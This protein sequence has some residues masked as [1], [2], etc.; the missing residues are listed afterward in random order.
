MSLS[1]LPLLA[2]LAGSPVSAQDSPLKGTLGVESAL[3]E[4]FGDEPQGV[5]KGT[6]ARAGAA[7]DIG[8]EW[9]LRPHLS[10]SG[11]ACV[12]EASWTGVTNGISGLEAQ[13]GFCVGLGGSVEICPTGIASQVFG[14]RYQKGPHKGTIIRYDLLGAGM[15]FGEKDSGFRGGLWYMQGPK[16]DET[17]I[18]GSMSVHSVSFEWAL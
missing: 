13:G 18:Q 12:G 11:K 1:S 17:G 2:S 6:C 3:F 14:S 10:G 15:V 9:P 16:N 4:Y 8:K 7:L 5:L